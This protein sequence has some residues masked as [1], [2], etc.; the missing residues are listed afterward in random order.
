MQIDEG[1]HGCSMYDG[2]NFH[3]LCDENN[4]LKCM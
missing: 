3:K 1:G 4:V 2:L